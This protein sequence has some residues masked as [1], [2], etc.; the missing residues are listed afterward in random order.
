[1]VKISAL[2][3]ATEFGGDDLVAIVQDNET[4]KITAANFLEQALTATLDQVAAEQSNRWRS[5][6]FDADTATPPTT[7]RIQTDSAMLTVGT[8][9]RVTQ[10]GVVRYAVVSAK[11]GTYV[12][13]LGPALNIAQAITAFEA[14][15][16]DRVIQCDLFIAGLYAGTTG[17]KVA[18]VMRTR[19]RW[20][21]GPARIVHFAA[22][23][24]VADTTVQPRVNLANASVAVS[25]NSTNQGILL[26]TAGTWV[27]NPAATIS[28]A[29]ATLAYGSVIEV[30]VTVAAGTGNASD[31]TVSYLAVLE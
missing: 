25:T 17:E 4:R 23:H 10:G 31:L 6:P 28:A 7:S 29:P 21:M 30:N 20:M 12:D 15:T 24:H 18:S 9:I 13:I 27:D 22:V 16:P 3:P 5:V 2:P 19:N 14:S 26:S 1:M 8:P 11:T